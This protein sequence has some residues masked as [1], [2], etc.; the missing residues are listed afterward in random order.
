MTREQHIKNL[1]ML[2]AYNGL[3]EEMV[4]SIAYSLDIINGGHSKGCPRFY[5]NIDDRFCTCYEDDDGELTERGK[6]NE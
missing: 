3:S 6:A 1:E 2:I 4:E 5:Q